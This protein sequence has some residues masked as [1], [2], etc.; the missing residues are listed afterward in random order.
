MD[1]VYSET[2][3]YRGHQKISVWLSERLYTPGSDFH[4]G[5]YI[6]A[7]PGLYVLLGGYQGRAMTNHFVNAKANSLNLLLYQVVAER[8]S[9]DLVSNCTKKN[10]EDKKKKLRDGVKKLL[11]DFCHLDSKR[12][13]QKKFLRKFWTLFLGFSQNEG[14]FTEWLVFTES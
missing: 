11:Y 10:V 5:D 2:G 8:L 1:P 4:V 14:D 3:I 9:K 7:D 13:K 6:A 12:I